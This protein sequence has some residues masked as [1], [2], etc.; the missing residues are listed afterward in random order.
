MIFVDGVDIGDVADVALRDRRMLSADGIFIV[1]ATISEQD[2]ASVADPEVIFRGVP[3]LEEADELLDEIRDDGRGLAGRAPPS[4]EIREID[5]LQEDAARRPRRVRL[6]APAP[7]A[8]GAAGRRRGLI[9]AGARAARGDRP[10]ERCTA[11]PD[12]LAGAGARRLGRRRRDPRR[13][14]GAGPTTKRAPGA[15][16]LEDDVAAVGDGDG[17]DDRQAR[18]RDEPPRSPPP[19]TKRSKIALA[20]L[21][22]DA[23]P[24]V[25]DRRG[26]PRRPSLRD[27][28]AR[29]RVPGGV[30][31]IAFSIR[32][33]DQPVQLVARALDHDRRRRRR[34]SSSWLGRQRPELGGGLDDDLRRGRSGAR[35]PLAPGVGAREQQQVGDQ[36][37]HPP[38]GAQRGRGGLAARSPSSSSAEQLEVGEDARQRRAQLVR[39]VGD[40]LRAGASSVASV[41]CAGGVERAEHLLERARQLGDL[42]VGVAAAGTLRGGV[43]RARDLARGRG[44]LGDRAPS[45]GARSPAPASS[46]SSGAAEHAERQEQPH[47]VDRARRRRTAAART[48]PDGIGRA[49]ALDVLIPIGRVASPTR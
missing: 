22:R 23:G 11:R 28:D 37:A 17:A 33:S 41:S 13:R 31:R 49:L 4:E 18:G 5:L 43:A 30:W 12:M 3:F 48:G 9:S 39:G 32:L 27:A 8:D 19:R 36:A 35:A 7:P 1:V 25:L 47:A 29:S 44:Q 40:E 34:P 14:R 16:V 20:Q 24:V 42:V 15:G 45:R 6:R 46:A 10:R 21:G 2:G 26:R 38:R